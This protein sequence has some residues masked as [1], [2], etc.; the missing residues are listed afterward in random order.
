MTRLVLGALGA[1]FLM[2][3][4]GFF[5]WASGVIDPAAHLSVEGEA[6]VAEALRTH[7]TQ[8]G[9]YFVPDAK[10]GTEAE[11]AARMAAGPF[12]MIYVTPQGAT[13]GDP[14][15]LAMG[16]AHM[17]VT[18]LLIGVI[19]RWT[20]P[21]TPSWMDR[22]NLVVL[23]GATAT[24]F[25]VLGNPIWWHHA[26]GSSLL[27]AAFDFGSYVIAGAVMAWAVRA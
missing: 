16:F 11:A 20:L 26:W 9:L 27:F 21:A 7:A 17:F 14:A 25:A 22:F 8:H 23:I 12:A 5:F 2:F 18:A 1:A 24:V 10:N 19:L 6:A 4:W 15:V 3:M 13:M